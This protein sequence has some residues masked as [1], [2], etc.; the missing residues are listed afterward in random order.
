MF[1][2]DEDGNFFHR[3]RADDMFVC[4]GKNIYPLEMELLLMKHPAVEQVCAA[5]LYTAE[6]G[7]VP[8][9]LIAIRHP[10]CETE[11]QDFSMR[12]GASHTIPQMVLLAGQNAPARPGQDRPS[13]RQEHA[14]A[15][16]RPESH[17]TA[18]AA[19]GRTRLGAMEPS[20]HRQQRRPV[21]SFYVRA[22]GAMLAER[23]PVLRDDAGE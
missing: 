17:H 7:T 1:I 16:L 8:A 11:V 12:N 10:V 15:G 2:K 19:I 23:R 3:G 18:D 14:A 6:K 5:P 9:V 22:S 21:G 4:N 13:A 20:R